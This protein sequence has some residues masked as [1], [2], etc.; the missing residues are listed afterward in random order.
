LASSE[1][2]SC[3]DVEI[4]ADFTLDIAEAATEEALS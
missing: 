4:D 2:S 3:E 1:V